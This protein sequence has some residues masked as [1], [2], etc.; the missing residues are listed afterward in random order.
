MEVI[1]LGQ[2]DN[3]IDRTFESANR[4]YSQLGVC[5]TISTCSGGGLQPKVVEGE[6]E[7]IAMRKY[8]IRKLTPRECFRLMNYTDEDYDR[9]AAVNSNTQLYKQA[10]N[11]IVK[12]CLMAIFSQLNIKGVKPWTEMTV[13]ERQRLVNKQF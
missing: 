13:E 1:T 12:S 11:A 2:M 9:A 5:P 3:T 4:V 6:T 7:K 8:R 10:G